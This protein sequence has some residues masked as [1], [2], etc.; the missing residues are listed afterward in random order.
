MVFHK[1]LVSNNSNGSLRV[2]PSSR[3]ALIR[4]AERGEIFTVIGVSGAWYHIRDSQQI[5][6]FVHQSGVTLNLPS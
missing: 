6:L 2:G 1:S 5:A 3:S 4:Q